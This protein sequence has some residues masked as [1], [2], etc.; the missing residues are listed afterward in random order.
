L[1]WLS[2]SFAWVLL[3]SLSLLVGL[4]TLLAVAGLAHQADPDRRH[5]FYFA[6]AAVVSFGLPFAL[7]VWKH[8]R[9]PHPSRTIPGTMAW[10]PTAW[11]ATGILLATLLVP[12]VLGTALRSCEWMVQGRFG[13]S[14]SM[15]RALSALGHETADLVDPPIEPIAETVGEPTGFALENAVEIPIREGAAILVDVELEG[16]AG[17]TPSRYLFDTGASYTTITSETAQTLGIEIPKDAPTLEFNTARGLGQSRM[18]Y[19]PRLRLGDV[20]LDGLLVSVCDSCATT[21]AGGLLGLNVIR[22][23]H[24]GMDYQGRQMELLPRVS[25][26]RPNRAYDVQP[27]VTIGIEGRPEIWLGRV[28]WIVLVE[29]R[30]TETLENVRPVVEF[31]EGPAL[32]GEV[33]ERIEPGRTGRSLL[34]GR[35]EDESSRRR[36]DPVEFTLSLAEAYW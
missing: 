8:R 10:L 1:V 15:T 33:I 19:L 23:F 29:N 30:G 13:D 3:G 11:N 22:E 25:A 14:H 7:A 21:Q 34:V 16:P 31:R 26:S 6:L 36:N 5:I 12:D 18:V 27:V 17:T 28:R 2:V 35:V 32:L 24:V 9:D 20:E 4:V